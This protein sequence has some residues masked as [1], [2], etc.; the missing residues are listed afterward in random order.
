MGRMCDPQH[1]VP[2]EGVIMSSSFD[3]SFNQDEA[4]RRLIDQQ[5]DQEAAEAALVAA[6]MDALARKGRPIRNVINLLAS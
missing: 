3:R 2:C 4:D 5:E 6:A 1:L